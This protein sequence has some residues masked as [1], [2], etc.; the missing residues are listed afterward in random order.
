MRPVTEIIVHCTATPPDWRGKQPFS[1][2]VAEIRRWHVEERGWSDIGYHYLIDRP[3][4]LAVGRPLDRVGAHV[5]GH[6][7]GT[8]GI[9]LLGGAGSAA[10]DQ[11]SDNYTPEQEAALRQLIAELKAKYPSIKKVSGHNE[12]AAK[13]CP[14]FNVARWYAHKPPRAVVASTTMQASMGQVAAGTGAVASGVAALDG[15]AQVVAL[16]IGGLVIALA[17]WVM[18]E[19]LVHWARGVR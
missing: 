14:G 11:F 6:N 4:T 2:K 3:G 5:A 8:I 7:I 17:L 16:V 1:L 18:R 9:C 15:T 19:R 10:T 12:Y 13:A